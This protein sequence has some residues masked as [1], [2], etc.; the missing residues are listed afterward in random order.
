M[1]GSAVHKRLAQLSDACGIGGN[2]TAEKAENFIAWIEEM[3]E[4]MQIPKGYNGF[5]EED[6][7]Q[8]IDWADQEA[9]P[10]YPV[11]VIWGREEF[12]ELIRR[13]QAF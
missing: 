9:N 5:R 2:S 13:L 7:E 4:K 8:I 12:R 1:Y 6:I 10:L 3:K 11:P